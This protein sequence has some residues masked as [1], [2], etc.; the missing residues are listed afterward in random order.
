M[1]IE[2]TQYGHTASYEFSHEDVALDELISV[3]ENLIKLTGYSFSGDLTIDEPAHHCACIENILKP[4][5]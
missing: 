3:L 4:K 1:K 5:R 2:I